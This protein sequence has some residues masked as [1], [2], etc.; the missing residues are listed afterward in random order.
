MPALK[1]LDDLESEDREHLCPFRRKIVDGGSIEVEGEHHPIQDIV[2]IIH[3]N[4]LWYVVLNSRSALRVSYCPR[5]GKS[6]V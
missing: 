6:L 1:H 2:R 3:R 5:C 4:R